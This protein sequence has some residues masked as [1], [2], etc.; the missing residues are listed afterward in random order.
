MP[1]KLI[2]NGYFR[3]GTTAVWEALRKSN[4]NSVVFYEPC[5]EKLPLILDVVSDEEDILHG[6]KLW[7]E[8]FENGIFSSVIRKVHPNLGVVYP[9]ESR[10]V[11]DYI[12][13]YNELE[14]NVILQTNRWHEYLYDIHKEYGAVVVHLI[15]NPV[16]I[17]ASFEES[18]FKNRNG[19]SKIKSYI[20]RYVFFEDV[21][22]VNETFYFLKRRTAKGELKYRGFK[23]KI[24]LIFH[25][26]FEKFMY[27][28]ILYNY[29]AFVD[30]KRIGG[31]VAIYEELGQGKLTNYFNLIG[32]D[33][34]EVLLKPKRVVFITDDE[35][36][37]L[38]VVADKIGLLSEFKYIL[39][40]INSL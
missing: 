19:F 31:H 22:Y 26:R 3:S 11:L 35:V 25:S 6:K 12:D 15:R 38:S 32:Y 29:Q 20:L 8:Y 33:F 21:F 36:C 17:Y 10:K 7:N 5:H 2:V 27:A 18:L 40:E 14:S 24:C 34:D 39:K 23:R 28:W 16:D 4:C 30:C 37:R 13:I 9:S 1:L